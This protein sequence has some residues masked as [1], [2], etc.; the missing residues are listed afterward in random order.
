MR[1]IY[2]LLHGIVFIN[3]MYIVIKSGTALL[4]CEDATNNK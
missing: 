2:I 4:R 1:T 3:A